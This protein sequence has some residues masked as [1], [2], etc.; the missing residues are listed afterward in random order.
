MILKETLRRIVQ[1]QRQELAI[2]KEEVKREKLKEIDINIP[3]AIV[4]SGIRRSGK[5]TLLK[6]I[7]GKVKHFYY[8]NFEDPRA[9]NFWLADF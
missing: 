1:S 6:Q 3:F 4:L 9:V 7:I 2:S 5:S 8:F